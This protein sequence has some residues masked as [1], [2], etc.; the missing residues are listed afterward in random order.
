MRIIPTPGLSTKIAAGLD[1]ATTLA[2][3]QLG[4]SFRMSATHPVIMLTTGVV[5]FV[6]FV[7]KDDITSKIVEGLGPIQNKNRYSFKRKGPATYYNQAKYRFAANRT[8]RQNKRVM[9]MVEPQT[10]N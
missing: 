10:V 2:V 6:L 1:I 5:T 4:Y 8:R 7:W 3:E 9:L